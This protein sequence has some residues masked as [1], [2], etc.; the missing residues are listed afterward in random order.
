MNWCMG[1]C[2]SKVRVYTITPFYFHSSI[3]NIY[4]RALL[5]RLPKPNPGGRGRHMPGHVLPVAGVRD[6]SSFLTAWTTVYVLRFIFPFF[7]L[8]AYI[9][10]EGWNLSYWEE[11]WGVLHAPD[12]QW[13]INSLRWWFQRCAESR[14]QVW[15]APNAESHTPNRRLPCI[16][17]RGEIMCM[18]DI[19]HKIS[20]GDQSCMRIH[21]DI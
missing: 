20:R 19:E 13:H 8:S 1:G 17:E 2:A 10:Q 16:R 15:P 11:A 9:V 3:W 5:F 18:L 7:L 6:P 12:C 14:Q 4:L 21:F